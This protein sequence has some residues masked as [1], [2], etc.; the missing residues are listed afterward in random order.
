MRGPDCVYKNLEQAREKK[1]PYTLEMWQDTKT[2]TSSQ[3]RSERSRRVRRWTQ[4]AKKRDGV[5]GVHPCRS[6]HSA[7]I[8]VLR[9]QPSSRTPR[10]RLLRAQEPRRALNNDA[11]GWR[12]RQQIVAADANRMQLDMRTRACSLA[13]DRRSTSQRRR[14]SAQTG[15]RLRVLL[16]AAQL[17]GSDTVHAWTVCAV[18]AVRSR[19][20]LFFVVMCTCRAPRGDTRSLAGTR[21]DGCG[22]LP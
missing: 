22:A 5:R 4:N 17:F 6:L 1:F 21:P 19:S 2:S 18:S 11:R 16:A 20:R 8:S 3:N 12:R 7:H 15:V 13:L 14:W 9:R 10:A